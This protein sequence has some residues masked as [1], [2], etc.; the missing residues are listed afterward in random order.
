MK[1]DIFF[2]IIIS[3]PIFWFFQVSM[4]NNSLPIEK[5]KTVNKIQVV[6]HDTITVETFKGDS[7]WGYNIFVNGKLYIH[8][9]NIPAVNGNNGFSK[10]EYAV[11]IAQLVI[12]KIKNHIFPPSVCVNELDSL[13]V[14]K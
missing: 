3:I 2:T 10:E 4:S 5:Q 13:Q 11:K 8:Q 6:N 1:K 9:P 7:G 12:E 14:L